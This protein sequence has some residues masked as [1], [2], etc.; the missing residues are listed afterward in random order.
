MGDKNP[1][2]V[3]TSLRK[4]A[5]SVKNCRCKNLIAVL[6]E[7][8]NFRN[9]AQTVRN[10]NALGVEKL[11]IIDSQGNMPNDWHEMRNDSKLIKASSS[12]IKWSFVKT[13][14]S[15]RECIDHLNKNNFISMVTSPHRKGKKNII[16]HEGKYT[17]MRLAV[18]FGSESR[19]ISE[20]AIEISAACIN[21]P[22]CGII[23]SLNLGTSTGIVLYEIAKQRREAKLARLARK[24]KKTVANNG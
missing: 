7:P 3:R 6:E 21:I 2:K 20:E 13:F 4:K 19:G 12:A 23:E 22:M 9:I 14:K 11:Y 10:I 15:T 17:R 1:K 5:D 24:D 8:Q 18:W 16:L